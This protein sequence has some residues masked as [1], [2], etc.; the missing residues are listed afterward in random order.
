MPRY[1][2]IACE[3]MTRTLNAAL[4]LAKDDITIEWIDIGLH[5]TPKLLHTRL[6]EILDGL[7]TAA[8]DAAL[9]LF[10][11]CGKATTLTAPPEIPLVMP[12]AHDCI[13]LYL[14]SA[15]RFQQEF[16]SDPGT[17]WYSVD[18]MARNTNQN[19]MLGAVSMGMEDDEYARLIERYG[20]DTASKIRETLT[21]WQAHYSRAVFI[22]DR[23]G[24]DAAYRLHAS[25]KAAKEGWAFK[26]ME[27]DNRL[28]EMLVTG[29]WPEDEF[30]V[31]PPGWRI[32]MDGSGGIVKAVRP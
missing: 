28:V 25:D 22:D 4:P 13:T 29:D 16:D 7:D 6:Q 26:I 15:A 31:V 11:L 19:N 5:S 3:V 14:G 12:R 23:Q 21:G 24:D 27:G 8:Y 1:A 17:Y 2:L 18:Y 30:V 10:G 9:L 32:E 20:L